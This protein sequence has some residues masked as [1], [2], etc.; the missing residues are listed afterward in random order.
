M[1]G[2]LGPAQPAPDGKES[3]PFGKHAHCG[4]H[5]RGHTCQCKQGPCG[6]NFQCFGKS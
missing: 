6:H 4:A 1:S 3:I 5:G 2:S